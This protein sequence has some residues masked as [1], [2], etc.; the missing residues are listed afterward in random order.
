MFTPV[1][2]HLARDGELD[3][4]VR[5]WG[6]PLLSGLS[7]LSLWHLAHFSTKISFPMASRR[8]RSSS[9]IGAAAGSWFALRACAPMPPANPSTAIA[10]KTAAVFLSRMVCSPYLV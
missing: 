3:V 5:P 6:R 8:P 10:I 9:E 7:P 2:R 1:F 4:L